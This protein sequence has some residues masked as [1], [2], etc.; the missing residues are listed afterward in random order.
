[1]TGRFRLT[2]FKVQTE[3]PIRGHYNPVLILL[4]STVFGIGS[5]RQIISRKGKLCLFI[6][7]FSV[8]CPIFLFQQRIVFSVT[9]GLEN[10]RICSLGFFHW[11]S[12]TVVSETGISIWDLYPLLGD[13]HGPLD[14]LKWDEHHNIPWS[15]P[16]KWGHKSAKIQK[17]HQSLVV[18]KNKG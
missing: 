5:L 3:L 9:I 7:K 12:N 13:H 4:T 10:G 11:C 16:Q 18:Q 15:Q 6:H 14:L 2:C 1:M 8:D 17:R